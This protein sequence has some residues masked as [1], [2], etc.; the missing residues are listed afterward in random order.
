MSSN[1][2]KVLNNAIGKAQKDQG[3][4]L[5]TFLVSLT[6]SGVILRLVAI[7]YV[8]LRFKFLEL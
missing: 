2:N 5:N 7:A 6:T 3:E 8:L 4:S 1:I